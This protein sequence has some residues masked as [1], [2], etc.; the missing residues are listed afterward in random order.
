MN[1]CSVC[2][3]DFECMRRVGQSEPCERFVHIVDAAIQL[4]RSDKIPPLA[5]SNIELLKPLTSTEVERI[6][7]NERVLKH[8]KQKFNRRGER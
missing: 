1:Y 6:D 3:H 2:V 7:T 4:L 8:L 5:P